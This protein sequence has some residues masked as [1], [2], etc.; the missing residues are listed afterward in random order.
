MYVLGEESI[1]KEIDGLEIDEAANAQAV[2]KRLERYI[3]EPWEQCIKQRGPRKELW[4]SSTIGT[5]QRRRKQLA[6]KW[7]ALVVVYR[8][9]KD[10]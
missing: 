2:L 7:H 3:N 9:N 8:T 5:A 4:R 10:K 1:L 6:R